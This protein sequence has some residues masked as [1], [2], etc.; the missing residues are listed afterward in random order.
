MEIKSPLN[1]IKNTIQ[2]H[3]SRVVQVEDRI[4]GFKYKIDIKE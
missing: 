3:H 2:S 1:Q 4:S